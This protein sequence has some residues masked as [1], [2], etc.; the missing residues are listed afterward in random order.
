MTTL[1]IDR[2]NTALKWRICRPDGSSAEGRDFVGTITTLS[3][4][5][6]SESMPVQRG[7]VSS[8]ASDAEN[9]AL[10]DELSALLGKSVGLLFA[11]VQDGVLGLSLSYE[12]PSMLGVDRW[13]MMLALVAKF[14][15]PAIVV[16]AGTA[17]TVDKVE[18][19]CRHVGGLIA[20]GWSTLSGSLFRSTSKLKQDISLLPFDGCA[21]GDNTQSCLDAGVSLMFLSFLTSIDRQFAEGCKSKIICGGDA[22]SILAALPLGYRCINS[23]VLDGL[24]VLASELTK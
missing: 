13:L 20:P 2:G 11:Q 18:A 3:N 14:E 15:L 22:E 23:L 17:L 16:S 4:A 24:E 6:S 7:F 12:Q 21:L 9:G 19:G 1:F 5:L 10:V 8:V